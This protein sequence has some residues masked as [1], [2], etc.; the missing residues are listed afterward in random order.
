[1]ISLSFTVHLD[2]SE[3][4]QL[5][6]PN[7]PLFHRWLPNG[8]NDS[9]VLYDYGKNRIEIWF[10]RKGKAKAGTEIIEYDKES[11]GID[12]EVMRRQAHLDAGQLWGEAEFEDITTAEMDALLKNATESEEYISIG[13]KVTN[14]IYGPVSKFIELLRCQYGQYWLRELSKWDSRRESLG[15][16]CSTTLWI[17]WRQNNDDNW[18]PFRPTKS[19]AILTLGSLPG[20]KNAEYITEEDWQNI[21]ETFNPGAPSLLSLEVYGRA[22]ELRE[23]GHIKE[24]FVTAVSALEIAIEE[25]INKKT[26]SHTEEG[27]KLAKKIHTMPLKTQVAILITTAS[28]APAELLEN[29]VTA[30]TTRNEIVHEGKAPDDP[31]WTLFLSIKSCLLGLLELR[32]IKSPVLYSGNSLSPP[33]YGGKQAM[34]IGES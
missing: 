29:V 26:L 31:D 24:A 28:I 18:Q 5:V 9:V 34:T 3:I 2:S 16:Y 13:K 19:S 20:R 8:R 30:I 12:E 25:Y 7:G 22:H 23:N 32:D 11:S 6:R 27:R 14:F 33:E 21:Q 17:E 15:K 1:M 4:D 10:D